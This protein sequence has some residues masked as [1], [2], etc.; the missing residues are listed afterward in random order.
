VEYREGIKGG[1]GGKR[2]YTAD[3]LKYG[4][5]FLPN[6]LGENKKIVSII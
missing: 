5:I 2:I 3:F 6:R 4:P 1:E